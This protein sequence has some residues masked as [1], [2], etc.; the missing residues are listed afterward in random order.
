LNALR[1]PFAY[2]ES[3]EEKAPMTAEETL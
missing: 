1:D 2:S 3:D